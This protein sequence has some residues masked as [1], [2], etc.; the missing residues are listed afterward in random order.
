MN[1]TF[2]ILFEDFAEI[3]RKALPPVAN[4]DSRLTQLG[5]LKKDFLSRL[6]DYYSAAAIQNMAASRGVT[7]GFKQVKLE[8]IKSLVNLF[9][10][11]TSIKTM[12][13][14]LSPLA[15]DG[16]QRLKR[17]GGMLSLVN[18]QA[19][20]QQQHSKNQTDQAQAELIGAMLMFYATITYNGTEFGAGQRHELTK[21]GIYNQR[22]VILWTTPQVLELVPAPIQP[23]SKAA[24][25][26]RYAAPVEPKVKNSANFESLLADIIAFLRYLDLNQVKILQSGDIGK[27]DFVKLNEL[28]SVKETG[29]IADL[30]KLEETGRLSFIW[31]LLLACGMVASKPGKYADNFAVVQTAQNDEF[32]ALPRYRQARLLAAAWIT[33]NFNDFSRIPTLEF[34]GG[35]PAELS[36]LPEPL[37]LTAA[38]AQ[39][40]STLES[41]W[42]HSTVAAQTWLD[43]SALVNYFRDLSP[44]LLIERRFSTTSAYNYYTSDHYYGP[45]YYNGFTSQLKKTTTGKKNYWQTGVALTQGEDWAL[46]EGEWLAEVFSEPLAWLGLAELGSN[47]NGRPLAFR[48]TTLGEAVLENRPTESEQALKAQL[49]QLAA[50]DPNL[51]KPLLVQPNFDVMILAPLQNMALLRQLDRFADQT[52]LGDVAMYR[53]NKESVLRGLRSGLNGAE[54]QNLL[55]V[56]SRVPV[57]QNITSTIRD[58]S[59]EFERLILHEKTTV[60][61]MPNAEMLDR[62]MTMPQAQ[63]VITRRLGPTFA[64]VSGNSARLDPVLLSLLDLHSPKKTSPV[65]L[66]YAGQQPGILS[67]EGENLLRLKAQSG[68]PYLYFRLGQFADLVEWNPAQM[69]ATFRLSAQAGQRAQQAGLTYDKVAHFVTSSQPEVVTAQFRHAPELDG[70][71]KLAMRGWLG[72][73]SPPTGHKA[74]VLRVKTR[75]QLDDIFS[76]AEFSPALLE[77]STP[78]TALIREDH[79]LRLRER[80][81]ELGMPPVA[82][83]FDP[84]TPLKLLPPLEEP[85]DEPAPTG[86]SRKPKT[87]KPPKPHETA[88]ERDRR[89][90]EAEAEAQS[91]WNRSLSNIPLNPLLAGSARPMQDKLEMI[92]TIQ[93]LNALSNGKI[94]L[95]GLLGDDSDFDEFDDDD[96][97]PRPPRP[98][99]RR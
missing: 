91:S 64:L 38:R 51:T 43:F 10:D 75:E 49:E 30:K 45:E 92:Q 82:P 60:I 90:R 98:R 4:I 35:L 68:N 73:Y 20:M 94:P 74:I 17:A 39:V 8:S 23:V 83:E 21:S 62:L 33:S 63:K 67:V 5:D 81:T 61:E 32:Y 86:K 69:S 18:W 50:A 77:R 31:N 22:D 84:P 44:D 78:T 76:I 28:M 59:N 54:V 37:K 3:G 53:L 96:Y 65:Y 24:G 72:Y 55:E 7:T 14:K 12:I 89:Q 36:D 70:P 42:Q 1:K 52:S 79:F 80:L 2:Q 40:M 15:L 66:D 93:L 27:R 34:T 6:L 26:Q 87:P 85:A 99:R 29:K 46:V 71:M 41:F 16:L 47:E 57:A 13:Q 58:W 95:D 25:W 9:Y 48:L 11:P 56:N 97:P 19:Q 88:A